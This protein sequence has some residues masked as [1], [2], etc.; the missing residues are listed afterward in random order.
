MARI[1]LDFAYSDGQIQLERTSF[2]LSPDSE[3]LAVRGKTAGAYKCSGSFQWTP[4]VKAVSVLFLH[5][6]A[7]SFDNSDTA[8]PM[9]CG[10]RGSLAS[11]LDY[12]IDKEPQ[13][14][15]DMFGLDESGK[16]NLRRLIFRSNP[17]GKRP[18]AV[19]ITLNEAALPAENIQVL[20]DSIPIHDREFLTSLIT[21]LSDESNEHN[22]SKQSDSFDSSVFFANEKRNAAWNHRLA[23]LGHEDAYGIPKIDT[24][25]DEDIDDI[26]QYEELEFPGHHATKERL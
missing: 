21:K 2:R 12:A 26:F 24:V 23:P 18:G 15:C 5:A 7:N 3:Y 14:L 22:K 10:K 13:W 6:L 20:V 25:T 19:S 8:M 9:I 4:A 16:T 1:T 11:S 17:G